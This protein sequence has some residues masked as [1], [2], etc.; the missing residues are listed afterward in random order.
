MLLK[1]NY[2]LMTK[3]RAGNPHRRT[4]VCS[5]DTGLVGIAAC[6]HLV[7]PPDTLTSTVRTSCE[8][9]ILL[10]IFDSDDMRQEQDRFSIFFFLFSSVKC[11]RSN[12]KPNY[13]SE[14]MS[15]ASTGPLSS[16]LNSAQPV[17][18]F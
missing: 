18:D 3:Y 15:L 11:V 2:A 4:W 7:Q 10:E 6:L 12:L 17:Q 14:H 1:V 13:K 8:F 9:L 5:H 16:S